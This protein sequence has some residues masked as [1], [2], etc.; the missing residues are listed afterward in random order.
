MCE[1]ETDDPVATTENT[2]VTNEETVVESTVKIRTVGGSSAIH[3]YAKIFDD[4]D[5]TK[6]NKVDDQV[7]TQEDTK[8]N[9]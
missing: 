1:S 4:D 5:A 6:F 7:V 8:G 9:Q 3:E 2:D